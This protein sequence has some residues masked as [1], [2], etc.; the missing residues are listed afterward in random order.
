MLLFARHEKLPVL[1]RCGSSLH[2]CS[3]S[4]QIDMCSQS[5]CICLYYLGFPEFSLQ[6]I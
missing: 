3:R 5:D 2:L 6:V 1:L 4:C